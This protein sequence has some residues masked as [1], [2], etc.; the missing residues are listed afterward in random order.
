MGQI[1]NMRKKISL[2]I[3]L[4]LCMVLMTGCTIGGTRIK[5]LQTLGPNQI[6]KIDG[7]VCKKKEARIYL[8]NYMNIYGKAYGIDLWE[9]E[10]E[11]EG[12]KQYVKDVTISA[13]AEIKC[14]NGIAKEQDI[15]LT[16]T[17]KK[18]AKQA[19]ETYYE[20]LTKKERRAMK[21]KK[22]LL[23][24]MYEEY[25]L[26]VKTADV[27]IES[28]DEEVSDDEARIMEAQ[29]IY[30]TDKK[31]AKE[32]NRRIKRG[33]TF[34]RIAE[35]F[36]EK[37]KIEIAFGRGDMPNEVIHAAFELE[38]DEISEMITTD[39][40]YYFIKCVNKYNPTLTDD[41]KSI[42]LAQRKTY[43]YNTVYNDYTDKVSSIMNEKA[44]KKVKVE[45]EDEVTTDDFFEVI[46][47][48]LER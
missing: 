30:V 44:W 35:T 23:C 20:S 16:K 28:V 11:T 33:E 14:L 19:A 13:L 18:I 48:A 40:G 42:I 46:D 41:N 10:F 1:T 7:E 6:F 43:A 39:D 8:I 5:I 32:V 2:I 17:E 29:Q 37:D 9:Q 26:A 36:N 34:L 27:L 24:D 47:E 31:K 3:S 21:A 12:L 38:N 4:M 22:S 15:K 45:P 25:I